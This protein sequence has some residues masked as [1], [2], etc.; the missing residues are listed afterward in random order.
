M[1]FC[2]IEMAPKYRISETERSRRAERLRRLHL[3]P[4]FRKKQRAALR[5]WRKR[6]PY[7][8]YWKK[9]TPHPGF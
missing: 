8:D 5:L 9:G 1:E 4:E 3:D 7:G 6:R 2:R